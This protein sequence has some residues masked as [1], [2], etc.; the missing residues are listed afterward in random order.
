MH[1]QPWHRRR[2][3]K[4]IGKRQINCCDNGIEMQGGEGGARKG[5]LFVCKEKT[6]VSRGEEK[7]VKEHDGT[8]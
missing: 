8:H 7:Q 1:I 6:L 3:V 2:H 5:R 4:G